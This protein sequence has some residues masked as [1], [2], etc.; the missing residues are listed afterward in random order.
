MEVKLPDTDWCNIIGKA[1]DMQ[2]RGK[3]EL[4]GAWSIF[5]RFRAHFFIGVDSFGCY[6]SKCALKEIAGMIGISMER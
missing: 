3:N 6:A 1:H 2:E 5:S 4:P